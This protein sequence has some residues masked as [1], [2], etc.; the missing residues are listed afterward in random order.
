MTDVRVKWRDSMTVTATWTE[1][2]EVAST[3][4]DHYDAPIETTGRLVFDEPDYIV[5]CSS[6]NR[7][8]DEL[9]GCMMIPRVV[10]I[11]IEKLE[12]A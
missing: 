7:P 9:N 4:R 2:A 3:A 11:E 1:S 6:Y 5:V 8:G 10:V 12:A